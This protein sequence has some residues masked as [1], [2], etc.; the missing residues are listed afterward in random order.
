M[1]NMAAYFLDS[2]TYPDFENLGEFYRWF[3]E[4]RA[5]ADTMVEN[6]PD[7]AL[8]RHVAYL[9]SQLDGFVAGT[10]TVLSDWDW[11]YAAWLNGL[12]DVIDLNEYILNIKHN[13]WDELTAREAEFEFHRAGHCSVLIKVSKA[14]YQFFCDYWLPV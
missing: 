1:Q 7:N 5:W 8:W 2:K 11:K 12:G 14:F 6:N 9:N 4:Q 13:D 10:K 3:T